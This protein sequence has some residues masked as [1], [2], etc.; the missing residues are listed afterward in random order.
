[1]D[2]IERHENRQQV[3]PALPVKSPGPNPQ[4]LHGSGSTVL[5]LA[6][7]GEA[8]NNQPAC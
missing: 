4:L 2:R 8:S 7:Q 5:L 6:D 3:L 1:M